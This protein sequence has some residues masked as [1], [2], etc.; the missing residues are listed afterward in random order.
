MAKVLTLPDQLLAKSK[1]Q[2]HDITLEAVQFPLMPLGVEHDK[3]WQ[4][5]RPLGRAISSDA[6][7]R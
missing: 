3:R 5:R 1:R 7:R 2:G 4:E 6:V